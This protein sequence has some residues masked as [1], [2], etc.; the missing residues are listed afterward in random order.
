MTHLIQTEQIS[1]QADRGLALIKMCL[2]SSISSQR[3]KNA[4]QSSQRQIKSVKNKLGK[5]S[6]G[7]AFIGLLKAGKSTLANALIGKRLLP[8]E[9]AACTLGVINVTNQSLKHPPVLVEYAKNGNTNVLGEGS[10]IYNVFLNRIRELRESP[11]T[12]VN[13]W[14]LYTEI[15]ALKELDLPVQFLDTQGLEEWSSSNVDTDTFDQKTLQIL[16]EASIVLI[17]LNYTILKQGGY[18]KIFSELQEKKGELL[19]RTQYRNLAFIVTKIDQRNPIDPSLEVTLNQLKNDLETFGFEK[20]LVF[21]V[22]ALEALL[23]KEVLN[24]NASD[25]YLEEYQT[26]IA[27]KYAIANQ[28]GTKLIPPASQTAP[29][30]LA[31]SGI[32]QIESYLSSTL[33]NAHVFQTLDQLIN[34]KNAASDLHTSLKEERLHQSANAEKLKAEADRCHQKERKLKDNLASMRRETD[35][36]LQWL[37]NHAYS[38]ASEVINATK[39]LLSS[40]LQNNR[41]RFQDKNQAYDRWQ[42]SLTTCQSIYLDTSKS[43]F[44]HSITDIQPKLEKLTQFLLNKGKEL[45]AISSDDGFSSQPLV[46]NLPT[47]PNPKLPQPTLPISEETEHYT[48]VHQVIEYVEVTEFIRTTRRRP[49]LGNPLDSI[50]GWGENVEEVKPY[51]KR[52]PRVVDRVVDKQRSVYYIDYRQG[53]DR[54]VQILCNDGNQ[55]KEDVRAAYL[56]SLQSIYKYIQNTEILIQQKSVELEYLVTETLTQQKVALS[57]C[58]KL[59]EFISHI[60]QYVSELEEKIE[61][62]TPT[63]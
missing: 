24:N 42:V 1:E 33:S 22:S 56:K 16:V 63:L 34:I 50:L 44:T 55:F 4:A 28:D 36:V 26:R 59:D 53:Y 12:S 38:D 5:L 10:D 13:H 46:V 52:E 47:V 41:E 11:N 29:V 58:V 18:K 43:I 21:A 6:Y 32:Q 25:E 9:N 23:A 37:T 54:I 27:P 20:P 39:S 61:I 2:D 35:A 15:E 45:E 17:V 8:S 14:E 57:N 40:C 60:N 31:N 48:E 62:F 51:T 30:A 19:K 49:V 7:I 3:V